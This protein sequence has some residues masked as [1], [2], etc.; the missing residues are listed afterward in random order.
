M[1]EGSVGYATDDLWLTQASPAR[2]PGTPVPDLQVGE[3]STCISPK[4]FSQ[5][6]TFDTTYQQGRNR[7]G[8]RHT[9]AVRTTSAVPTRSR[10]YLL[11]VPS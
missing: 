9:S 2:V 11:D 8:G 1:L 3:I 6:R 7:R 4:S 10:T 5:E